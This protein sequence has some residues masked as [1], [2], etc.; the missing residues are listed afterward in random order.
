MVHFRQLVGLTIAIGWWSSCASPANE[1]IV[2]DVQINEPQGMAFE[3]PAITPS[4]LGVPELLSIE[5]YL[6]LGSDSC[7]IVLVD[8]RTPEEYLSGHL[9][10]AFQ[11]W[12]TDLE[13]DHFPYEGMAIGAEELEQILAGLG[14]NN[15]S[16]IVV[17]DGVGGCD[18]ARLWWL[19]ELYGHTKVSLLDGG[20][21]AWTF[22]NHPAEQAET[23]RPEKGNLSLNRIPNSQLLA[24]IDDLLLLAGDSN[25][26]FLDTR[27]AEEHKGEVLK[28]GA[29]NAGHIPGSVHFDWGRAVDM[30]QAFPL[31][32]F[33]EIMAALAENGVTPQ[34]KIITYCH[35]G[36]RSAHTTFVLKE[37]LGF[38]DVSNYDGS[39]IEWS[40]LNPVTTNSQ[41][42]L[43][44][45]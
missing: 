18:A 1:P 26:V 3:Y 40:Y 6:Q 10:D 11:L 36:V 22:F 8:M 38:P 42:I 5:H 34:K 45:A 14:A 30:N 13:S 12:R 2:H 33:D 25:V 28:K 29:F 16:H 27:S 24:T 32:P 43:P 19:L 20:W 39:W 21:M 37:L 23:P 41:T 4:E 35:S 7:D 31:R 44:D 17:Y 15:S 9:P